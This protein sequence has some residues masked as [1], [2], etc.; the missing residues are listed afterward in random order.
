MDEQQPS[1]E[2]K[3]E[4]PRIAWIRE[5]VC[6]GLDITTSVFYDLLFRDDKAAQT[7]LEEYL[8]GS[9]KERT[10]FFWIVSGIVELGFSHLPDNSDLSM[11][12][13]KLRNEVPFPED[14]TEEAMHQSFEYGVLPGHT[15]LNLEHTIQVC[16]FLC[17]YTE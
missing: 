15:L 12:F 1:T 2:T 9:N 16:L 3:V 14:D 7:Q 6:L 5:K 17:L 8:N 13:L 4:D 11:F 10:V